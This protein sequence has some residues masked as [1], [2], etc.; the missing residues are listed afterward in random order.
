MYGESGGYNTFFHST[1]LLFFKKCKA[2][3]WTGTKFFPEATDD[4]PFPKEYYK[5]TT[6][7]FYET[8]KHIDK[9]SFKKTEGESISGIKS[10]CLKEY[11]HNDPPK[12]GQIS[13]KNHYNP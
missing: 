13:F 6:C 1:S 4:N 10:K 9:S 8:G 2:F 12:L 7:Y 11:K 5:N 3:S